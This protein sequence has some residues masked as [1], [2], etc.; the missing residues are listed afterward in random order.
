MNLPDW[1]KNLLIAL[2]LIVVLA[3]LWVVVKVIID[4]LFVVAVGAAALGGLYLFAKKVHW[5]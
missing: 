2:L 3:G 5:L 1:L 4:I